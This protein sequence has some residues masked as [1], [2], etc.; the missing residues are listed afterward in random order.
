MKK[1]IPSSVAF[2]LQTGTLA[3]GVNRVS[4]SRVP[5]DLVKLHSH[6]KVNLYLD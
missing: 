1:A 4:A 2:H 5:P 6:L 3:D